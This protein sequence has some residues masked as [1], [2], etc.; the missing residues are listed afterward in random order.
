MKFQSKTRILFATES[1][2]LADIVMNL[3]IFFFV[4][5]SFFATFKKVQQESTVELRLPT[6]GA[7]AIA[8]QKG[9]VVV[10]IT[11]GGEIF[12][13]DK[14]VTLSALTENIRSALANIDQ[15][16][17]VVRADKTL[18]LEQFV[19]VIEAIKAADVENIAIRTEAVKPPPAP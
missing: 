11:A 1:I 3:F 2:A 15:K 14:A 8:P 12:L 16:A 5:F 4:T 9:P 17:V 13:Q 6:T 19:G 18:Q 10:A 7:G